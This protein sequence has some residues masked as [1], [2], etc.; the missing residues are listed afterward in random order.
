MQKTRQKIIEYLR[1]NGEATVDELSEA[2]DNLTAVT[3][4]HHLDVL[5]SDGLVAQPEVQ[6]RVTPGRPKY[7]YQLTDKAEQMFP[8]NLST[9]ASSMVDEIKQSLPREQAN[10]IFEGVADRMAA[11]LESGPAGEPLEARLDRVVAHLTQHGY[12]AHWEKSEAGYLLHTSNCPYS[13][14]ADAHDDLCQ[15]DMR[16]IS[17]LLG[18]VPRRTLHIPEGDNTCSYLIMDKVVSH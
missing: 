6:H 16:Y 2:L 17:K 1:K 7:I 12:E 10:V 18:R 4:R 5:R 11:S 8:R 13:G 15:I 14:V 3:V 9:L